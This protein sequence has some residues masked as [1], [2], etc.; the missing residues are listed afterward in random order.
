M[1]LFHAL[2]VISDAGARHLV[3]REASTTA[4][5]GWSMFFQGLAR[6]MVGTS[7]LPFRFST[8]QHFATQHAEG[9][10][11]HFELGWTQPG[12]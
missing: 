2:D 3:L 6:L 12:P 11:G 9:F 5:K 1:L 4:N 10:R 8:L 7:N